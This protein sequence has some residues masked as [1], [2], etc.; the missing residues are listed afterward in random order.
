MIDRLTG[1]MV[2]KNAAQCV[3]DCGGVGYE[4]NI[5]L[6]TYE[7][8]PQEEAVKLFTHLIVREDAQIL[9]G[10]ATREERSLFRLLIS[11]SGIG[12]NTA[13]MILS[14]MTADELQVTIAT[15][16]VAAL[17]SVKGIG[18]KSAER[19]IIDLKDK[20]GKIEGEPEFLASGYNTTRD[21]ALK[22]LEV[23]GYN[24]QKASK[25]IDQALASDPQAKVE[26]LIKTAL[27]KL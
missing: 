24:R 11:V 13:R 15:G 1:R 9:F 10:F 14:S 26:E 17:K 23:L 19:V 20:V 4:V 7:R 21:E 5:S 8:L 27:K 22:A 18:A 2:E 6:Q 16:N 25:I 3:I 12:P